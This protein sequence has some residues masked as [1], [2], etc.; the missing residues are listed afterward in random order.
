MS[1]DLITCPCCDGTGRSTFDNEPP[2]EWFEC[3]TCKGSGEAHLYERRR[4]SSGGVTVAI[5]VAGWRPP[6]EEI[7]GAKSLLHP[8]PSRTLSNALHFFGVR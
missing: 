1:G 3:I 8:D 6:N 5:V 2:F 7:V 4:V